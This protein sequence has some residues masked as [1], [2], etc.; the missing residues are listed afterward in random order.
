MGRFIAFVYGVISYLIF[1]VA[2]LY[3]IGFVGNLVVPKSIDTAA[4][5]EVPFLQA[6]LINA[7]LL[8]LFA[9]RNL[10]PAANIARRRRPIEL[11]LPVDVALDSY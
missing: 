9:I 6:L 4:E 10:C 8:G 2:F 7:L 3:A 11:L 1:F 5:I